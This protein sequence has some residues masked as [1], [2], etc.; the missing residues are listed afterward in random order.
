M[1]RRT[2]GHSDRKR[3]AEDDE[4]DDDDERRRRRASRGPPTPNAPVPDNGLF[5]GKTRPKVEVQ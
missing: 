2:R 3:Y 4:D 1:A 5:N